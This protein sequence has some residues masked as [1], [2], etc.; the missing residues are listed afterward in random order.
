MYN[1]FEEIN[2][3]D[4]F[5]TNC[6]VCE[7]KI[8]FR[9]IDF[10]WKPYNLDGTEHK[11]ENVLSVSK[12]LKALHYPEEEKIHS[13]TLSTLTL[14]QFENF[15]DEKV[16]RQTKMQM[17]TLLHS[18]KGF[19]DGPKI[20]KQFEVEGKTFTITGKLDKLEEDNIIEAKFAWTYNSD[21]KN[22]DYANDQCDI[23][24][25]ITGKFTSTILIHNI[26]KDE[27]KPYE[28][29]NNPKRGEQLVRD[30]VEN[31]MLNS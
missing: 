31:N 11:D 2:L 21:E 30:Y 12:V 6:Y 29:M 3:G 10:K 24:G 25:W 18:M 14:E 26:E 22:F 1:I 8:E 23:Y 5:Q 17:S 16:K 20:K 15:I 28:R 27:V 13:S 7:N 9:K 4:S 19:G